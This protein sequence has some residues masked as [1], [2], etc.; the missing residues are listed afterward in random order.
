MRQL[1]Q[2]KQNI[3]IPE[4]PGKKGLFSIDVFKYSKNEVSCNFFNLKYYREDQTVMI[5]LSL[6]YKYIGAK[7]FFSHD[8]NRKHFETKLRKFLL[9]NNIS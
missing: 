8:I 3:S 4:L 6:K 2:E 1:F 5:P 9:N 7:I